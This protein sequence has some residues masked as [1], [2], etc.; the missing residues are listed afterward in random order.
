MR[1]GLGLRRGKGVNHSA[2]LVVGLAS[3]AYILLAVHT[4]AD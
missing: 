2:E 4:I 3:V 1:R